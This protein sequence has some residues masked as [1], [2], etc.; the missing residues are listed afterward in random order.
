M[1]ISIQGSV[2]VKTTLIISSRNA[3]KFVKKLLLFPFK[4][5]EKMK[6]SIHLSFLLFYLMNSLLGG[7]LTSVCQ[8]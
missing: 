1:E 4:R 6:I 5:G 3:K 8:M 7:H 2:E